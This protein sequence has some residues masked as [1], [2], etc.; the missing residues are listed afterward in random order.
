MDFRDLIRNYKNECLYNDYYSWCFVFPLKN[1][2][3]LSIIMGERT[4]STPQMKLPLEDYLQ[5]EAA[6]LSPAGQFIHDGFLVP[7]D[8]PEAAIA[9]DTATLFRF[10]DVEGL[11]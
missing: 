7:A 1:G 2:N 5:V 8:H 9:A 6:I 4:L 3:E 11:K 10:L